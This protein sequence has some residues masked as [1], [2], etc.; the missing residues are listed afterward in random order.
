[1]TEAYIIIYHQ[2]SPYLKND[3]EAS[4]AF[5]KIRQDQDIFGLLKLI[6]GLCCS[7]D[8]K[9]QGVIATVASHKQLFTHYQRNG[10]DNHTY[11]FEFLAHVETIETYGAIGAIGVVPAFLNMKIKEMADVNLISD[12]NAPTDKEIAA[13]VQAVCDE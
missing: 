2:C 3:L 4:D 6:Q 10:I 8:A 13:A 12:A 1:M 9:T 7:Y 11:H 5:T